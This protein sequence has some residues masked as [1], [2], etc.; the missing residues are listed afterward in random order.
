M[1]N[2][3]M[4]MLMSV[5]RKLKPVLIWI[6]PIE[7][8]RKIKQLITK[9][10]I[11]RGIA[12]AKW[13][14]LRS[15]N[16]DGINYIGFIQGE[17]GLGQ[18]CRLIAAALDKS[19]IDFT[20]FN[21]EQISAMRHNDHSWD[22]KIT[23]KTPYNI[24]LFHLNPPELALAYLTMDE[25]TWKDKYNI[26]FWLW[27]LE[28][29]PTEW[30]PSLALVDEIWTPADFVTD[31]FRKVTDKPV[32]TIPYPVSAPT[33]D[34]F[35][36][37]YFGLPQERFLFLTMYDCNSTIER[38]NPLG[39]IEAFKRAFDKDDPN[40]GLVI[41]VNNPQQ[42]DIDRIKEIIE[43]YRNVFLIAKT[44]S[45]VEVNSLIRCCDVY[46]SLHRAEGYGLPMAEAMVLGR[47]VIGTNWS[48]NTEFMNHSN[49]CLVDFTIVELQ[50]DYVMYKKG[51]H[52]AQPDVDQASQYMIRCV[53]D[54]DYYSNLARSAKEHMA[55]FNSV[56]IAA[57]RINQ[58]IL[59]IYNKEE[60]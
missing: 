40:V 37:T 56:D 26:A 14:F 9:K 32:L 19:P 17:I 46:V 10:S 50:E 25:D 52:W 48:A 4:R 27:E 58:R 55:T 13:T 15:K 59:E 6:F 8:L 29:F 20:V 22:H 31:N 54:K 44:I 3:L 34:A 47:V 33:S 42:K 43:G 1:S 35:D 24:N 30:L 39:S 5:I 12:D 49:S 28:E 36:R 60:R 23:N 21:F 2:S 57:Q 38:K 11:E 16:P 51:S 53:S 18:S 45:K 7:W 41:K